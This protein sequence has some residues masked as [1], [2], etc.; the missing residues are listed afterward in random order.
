MDDYTSPENK[1]KDKISIAS[2]Q[3]GTLEIWIE[4]QDENK[5]FGNISG[6]ASFEFDMIEQ[7]IKTAEQMVLALNEWIKRAKNRAFE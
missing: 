7:D 2:N 4:E 6:F 3:D 1:H 5:P